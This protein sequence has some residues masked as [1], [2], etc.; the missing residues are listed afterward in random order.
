[1]LALGKVLSREFELV[2]A[3]SRFL[4]RAVQVVVELPKGYFQQSRGLPLTE[5]LPSS[6]FRSRY[7]VFR[8]VHLVAG[9]VPDTLQLFAVT[10]LTLPKVHLTLM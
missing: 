5:L 2:G 1:M 3:I 6:F 4:Q 10:I 9:A 8:F 7:L